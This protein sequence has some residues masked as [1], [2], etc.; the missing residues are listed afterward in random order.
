VVL[1]PK[2]WAG[3]VSFQQNIPACI[4]PPLPFSGKMRTFSEDFNL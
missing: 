1:Q 4:D 3:M 2:R